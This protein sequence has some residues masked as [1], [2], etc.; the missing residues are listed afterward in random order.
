MILTFDEKATARDAFVEKELARYVNQT[1]AKLNF[2]QD[3]TVMKVVVNLKGQGQMERI[4]FAK[5]FLRN[6]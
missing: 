5:Y 4:G 1:M 6:L 2:R 3:K